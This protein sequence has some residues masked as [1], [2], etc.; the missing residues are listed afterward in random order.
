MRQLAAFTKKEWME[1][2]RT[3]KVTILAALFILFGIMNP[4]F[5]KMTPWIM[6]QFSDSL[7]E[8]GM[9]VGEVEVDALTSWTQF[10]KNI[11]MALI[12]FLLM[13]SGILAT[14]YQKGTLVNM[15]TKGLVRWKIVV[16]KTVVM[17][18]LWS[19]G[20]W[21]C[22][23]ITYVYNQYFWDNSIADYVVFAAFCVYMLGIWLITLLMLMSTLFSSSSGV[24][25][26]TG[27]IFFV[28]Y[29]VSI[30]PD[31][32]EYLPTNLMNAS[33]LLSGAGKAGDYKWALVIVSILSVVNI[34]M[35][36]VMFNRKKV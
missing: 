5:A 2:I 13:F 10:Y 35:A 16:S 15:I 27:G 6:E 21:M 4:A 11:P 25:V 22:Y 33:G 36:M 3:G 1:V 9:I 31:I 7:A 8:A 30:V 17:L 12:V 32:K 20:Y 23:G 19:V 14:E 18:L 29:L 26:E 34:V 28:M 24:T